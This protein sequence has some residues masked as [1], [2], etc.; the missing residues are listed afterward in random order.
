VIGA[1][2]VT[3]VFIECTAEKD[4]FGR[5]PMEQA[6]AANC[7][8]LD[9][10]LHRL[11][12][13]TNGQFS[14]TASVSGIPP[15]PPRRAPAPPAAAAAAAVSSAKPLAVTDAAAAGGTR[16]VPNPLGQQS[17]EVAEKAAEASQ[18]AR[19]NRPKSFSETI[20]PLSE[21]DPEI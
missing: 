1:G 14:S 19:K 2:L 13:G 6:A 20:N 21:L 9:R 8:C 18:A 4:A 3:L 7:M 10:S 12:R 16:R 17:V 11:N 15:E 5:G